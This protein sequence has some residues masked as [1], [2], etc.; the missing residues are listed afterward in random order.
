MVLRTPPI[1]ET[2]ALDLRAADTESPSYIEEPPETPAPVFAVRAFRTALFGTPH[3]NQH[4]EAVVEEKVTPEKLSKAKHSPRAKFTS[5]KI[6]LRSHTARAHKAT[7]VLSPAKG[8]LVT[9]GTAAGRRKTVS[10]GSLENHDE[11]KPGNLPQISQSKGVE[12]EKVSDT[13]SPEDAKIDSHNLTKELFEAQLDASKQRLHEQQ[14]PTKPSSGEKS[15]L[16]EIQ[17]NSETSLQRAVVDPALDITV[18]LT[19]PRSQSGQHWKAEYERYQKNS[20]RELK[21]IIQHGQNVKSYAEKKDVEATDLQEKLKRELARCAAMETKVSGLAM[22]LAKSKRQGPEGSEDQEKLMND[23][24]R[25][26]ALAIRYKQKADR[27]KTAIKQQKLSSVGDT[28]D[29]DRQGVED[30]T[31]DTTYA[32]ETET[33]YNRNDRSEITALRNELD[34][35]RT[36]LD[37]AEERAA[38]LEAVNAKLTKNFLRVKDEMQNYDGRRVRRETRLKQ[39]EEKLI[40]EKEAYEKKLKQLSKEHEEFLRTVNGRPGVNS[41]LGV[42]GRPGPTNDSSAARSR[43]PLNHSAATHSPCNRTEPAPGGPAVDIWTMDTPND[44]ANM[45]PP[46]AEPAIT[47]PHVALSEATK[48]ALRE[49]DSNSV[50]DPPSEPPLPPDTPRPTLEHLAKMDS[51]LHPD[52]PQ[53]SESY[54]SSAAKRMN[55]RR[56]TIASPRPSM[57]NLASSAVIEDDMPRAAGLRRNA[58]L[59]ST[60]GSRRPTLNGGRSRVAELPPDRAA[61]AKARLAQ[62]KSMKENTKA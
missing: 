52:F 55:D 10:F 7:Q 20:D 25:Q 6:G 4:D 40:A 33:I 26:T 47:L 28:Y 9:P 50:S 57:V 60:A 17:R 42:Y 2:S 18:D 61:A 3:P 36:K 32:G 43:V 37:A 35:M 59:V 1:R 46:A 48:N 58:S 49:I 53:W 44:T 15:S 45:T 30:G 51:A 12:S 41:K 23:L 22:Q 56:N 5:P 27:Y 62:R 14:K 16:D 34:A 39:R 19:K 31:V 24:S 29:E 21:K 38:R 54:C 13:V 8:I 11:A